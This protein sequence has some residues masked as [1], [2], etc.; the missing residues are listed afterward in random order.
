MKKK[1]KTFIIAEIGP[2]HNGSIKIAK[3]MIRKLSSIDI[4]AIK[5]Q[6]GDPNE[7]YS[8][9]AFKAPYQKKNDKENS[10]K[11]MSKKN[12]L[13][14]SEHIAISK[15]CN[16]LGIPYACTA[17]DLKSLKFLNKNF[18]LPFFKIPSGEVTSL[19]LINY[20]S[21]QKKPIILST[22]MSDFQEIKKVK[23]MLE[24]HHKNKITIL[25]CVSEY[26]AKIKN[27]NLNIIDELKRRFKCDIGYSD[28]TNEEETCISAV[29]KGATIIEKHVTLDRNAGGPD[30]SFS[31]ESGEL[32]SLCDST[33]IAWSSVG[34][35]DYGKKS[36][37]IGNI[38][39]RRS[40]YV[41][42]NLS[43]GDVITE[44]NVKSIRPGY[45]LAP[46][47]MTEIVGKKINKNMV[48]G[49]SLQSEDIEGFLIKDPN[50]QD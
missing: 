48:A 4:D 31:L 19:D 10:V 13:S 39:F 49:D 46:K 33:K 27:V 14:K 50:V 41:A 40:L 34:R 44:H 21:K 16:K 43:S 45:G 29:A 24:K 15:F 8:D 23:S 37:E 32:K 11:A 2:N 9:D 42:E 20:I 5:F 12:Q 17:F 47:Y 1:N 3:K 7:V 18:K 36:S 38:Q 30:D 22:G 26:P 35:V 25:H 6:L 28:H